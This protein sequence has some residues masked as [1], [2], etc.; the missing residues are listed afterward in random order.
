MQRIGAF[1]WV[2]TIVMSL[3]QF[4]NSVGSK[5]IPAPCPSL[6]VRPPIRHEAP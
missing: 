3:V 6:E 1:I 4:D 2:W 5:K